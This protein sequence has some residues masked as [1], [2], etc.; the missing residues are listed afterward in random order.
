VL[1]QRLLD[2]TPVED[3]KNRIIT[4]IGAVITNEMRPTIF[5]Y[6]LEDPAE[7]MSKLLCSK[8]RNYNGGDVE[9][10]LG[11]KVEALNLARILLS[12]VFSSRELNSRYFF[13][14]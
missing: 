6:L 2:D 4:S 1:F 5:E 12:E 7:S 9:I 10:H 11:D 8:A 13:F 3:V 14:L